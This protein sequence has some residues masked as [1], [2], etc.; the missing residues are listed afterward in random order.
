MKL[1]QDGNR[2]VVAELNPISDAPLGVSILI[3]DKASKNMYEAVL[4]F[5]ENRDL[6]EGW[7]PIPVYEPEEK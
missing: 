7:L 4:F 5:D 2:I 3:K 6:Y 1:H